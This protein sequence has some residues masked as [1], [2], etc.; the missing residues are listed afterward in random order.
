[1]ILSVAVA[2]LQQPAPN[3]MT[4]IST[5]QLKAPVYLY[6]M[7]LSALAAISHLLAPNAH[8]AT[9]STLPRHD[10]CP[11]AVILFVKYAL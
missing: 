10:A 11:A 2:L 5:P 1:M 4:G 7:Y 8:L 6:V 9:W 3:A